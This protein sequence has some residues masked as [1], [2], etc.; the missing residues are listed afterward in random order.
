MAIRTIN[1]LVLII[2][3]MGLPIAASGGSD[4][5]KP[6]SEPDGFRGIKWGTDILTLKGMQLIE[7]DGLEKYYKKIEDNLTI[8]ASQLREITYGFRDGKFTTVIIRAKGYVNYGHLKDACFEKFGKGWRTEADERLD[9][10]SFA[11]FGDITWVSLKY[12][13]IKDEGVLRFSLIPKGGC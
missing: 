3:F 12:E 4:E 1:L 10:Q 7:D 11:W 5:F 9:I 13:K 6:G 2:L 8:G